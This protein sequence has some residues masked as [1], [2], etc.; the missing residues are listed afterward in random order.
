MCTQTP[1]KSMEADRISLRSCFSPRRPHVN[2]SLGIRR[3]A[4]KERCALTVKKPASPLARD[5]ARAAADEAVFAEIR[6]AAEKRQALT[7]SLREA[8]LARDAA[9]RT[10]K[11]KASRSA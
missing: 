4:A 7:S 1:E 9:N 8:R 11:K 10:T 6:Q 2:T 3:F 5:A